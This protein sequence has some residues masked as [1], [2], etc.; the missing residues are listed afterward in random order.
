MPGIESCGR[1]SL[2]ITLSPVVRGCL[3]REAVFELRSDEE[4][5]GLSGVGHEHCGRESNNLRN[6]E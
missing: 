5:A 1:G 6:P 4:R 3:P 2:W